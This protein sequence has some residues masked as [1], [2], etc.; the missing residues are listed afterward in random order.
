MNEK[1]TEITGKDKNY[2]KSV[3]TV[4]PSSDK[5]YPSEIRSGGINQCNAG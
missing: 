5:G 4:F 1:F 2:H 3:T